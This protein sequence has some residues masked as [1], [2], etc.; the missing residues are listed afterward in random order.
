LI[1]WIHSPVGILALMLMCGG[2]GLADVI[3][4]RWGHAKLPWAPDK[5]W[6]GSAAMFGGSFIFAY[7]FIILFDNLGHFE[8]SLTAAGSAL[9]IALIAFVA[10]LVESLPFPDIDNITITIVAIL[11]AWLLIHP[12]GLWAATFL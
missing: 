2:D 7:G 4:R 11:T 9:A 12:L 1:F 5:S 6:V 10:T 3:G 8:P